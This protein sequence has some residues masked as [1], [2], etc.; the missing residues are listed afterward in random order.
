MPF[1]ELRV[2]EI[3][4]DKGWTTKVLSEKTGMSESYLTHIKNGTRRWNEDSLKK[5]SEALGMD[6]I[7]LLSEYSSYKKNNC[8]QPK[9]DN[10]L[11]ESIVLK[12]IPVVGEIPAYP[13]IYNNLET[14]L[15]TGY[16][17]V[18]VPALSSD[19]SDSA[20][21]L[22]VENH[23]M[24]P[25]FLKKDLLLIS[26]CTEITSKTFA[27]VEYGKE[28]SRGLFIVTFSQNFI[29]LESVNHKTA[30][31]AL[32]KGKDFFRPIGKVVSVYQRFF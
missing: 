31:I 6:P 13:S 11:K 18:F 9:F 30:P 2:R 24:S 12:K 23:S 17:D 19:I 10:K 5:I 28:N 25:T 21:C 27:A 1:I 22:P 15:K 32:L 7:A 4:K 3:L 14:Q 26:P 29:M 16:K 8:G 20:F